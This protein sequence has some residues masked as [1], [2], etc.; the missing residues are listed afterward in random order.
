[1]AKDKKKTIEHS[2]IEGENDVFTMTHPTAG[3]AIVGDWQ[4]EEFLAA[5]W[6]RKLGRPKAD[7]PKA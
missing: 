5:G 3:D 6:T 7:A 2:H 1:M 4:E